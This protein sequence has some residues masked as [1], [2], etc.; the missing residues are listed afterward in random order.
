VVLHPQESPREAADS[1]RAGAGCRGVTAS[2][3][4]AVLPRGPHR[5]FREG[6]GL[7]RC[8]WGVLTLALTSWPSVLRWCG[9]PISFRWAPDPHIV[10]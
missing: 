5:P 2:P 7:L 1:A 10:G 4:L 6:V 8:P 9:P 3:R